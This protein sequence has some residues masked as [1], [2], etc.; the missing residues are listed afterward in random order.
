MLAIRSLF[1]FADGRRWVW[2]ACVAWM[3]DAELVAKAGGARWAPSSAF[4][5]G[6][7]GRLLNEWEEANP[8][9]KLLPKQVLQQA[10]IDFIKARQAFL[11]GSV[12]RPPRFQ[13]ARDAVPTLR[14]PQHV[15]L[16]QSAIFFPKIGWVKY[17]NSFNRGRGIPAGELRSATVRFTDGHWFV[18]LLLKTEVDAVISTPAAAV[19]LDAGVENTLALSSR[20][21]LQAPLMTESEHGRILFLERRLA[22]CSS[23]SGRRAKALH[24]LNR[25]RSRI[26]RRIHDWRHKSTTALSKNHGL[27]AVEGLTLKGMTA[28]AKG[29]VEAPGNKVAQKSG[30]NRALLEPGFGLI[31]EMLAYKQRDRGHAFIRVNPA[32][33]SQTCPEC[34]H[35]H[36]GNRPDRDTF[37]CQRCGYVDEADFVGARNVLKRAQ[38]LSLA[39]LSEPVLAAG[40]GRDCATVASAA[41][42]HG[43]PYPR[44]NPGSRLAA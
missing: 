38:H 29:T 24:R 30:L 5:L 41:R 14:F 19:G 35:V 6:F 40:H 9:L 2:N 15:R 28:S 8:W 13:K 17:R 43:S 31:F 7:V 10:V 3:E 26:N 20:I 25:F 44:T 33:T 23:G 18:S 16:N 34:T 32:Y 27:I 21:N 12:T 4:S 37:R 1:G 22:R 11:S 36:P 42:A 39:A